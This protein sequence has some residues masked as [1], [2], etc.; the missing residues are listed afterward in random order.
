MVNRNRWRLSH[1]PVRNCYPEFRVE[2][3]EKLPIRSSPANGKAQLRM[4]QAIEGDVLTTTLV[5]QRAI[6]A[7]LRATDDILGSH[8][9][10]AKQGSYQHAKFLFDFAG[11]PSAQTQSAP[12]QESL[13]SIL[14]K[15]LEVDDAG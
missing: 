7:I 6:A 15:R 13:A 10:K 14:L 4:A 5:Q 3:D 1:L 12:E 8:I 11:L 2:M 9:K